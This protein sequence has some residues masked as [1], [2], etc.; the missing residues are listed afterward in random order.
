MIRTHR[1]GGHLAGFSDFIAE[2]RRRRVIR[3]LIGWGIF[4]FAVLQVVEPVLHAFHLPEW[5]LTAVVTVLGAGFP[6]TVVLA[7]VFDFTAQGITR[8]AAAGVEASPRSS[9]TGPRL[10]MLL[11]ALGL[12]A[13]APGV[14]YLFVWPGSARSAAPAPSDAQATA[15]PPSIAVLAFADLSPTKDQ[16]YFSDGIAEE[17]LNALARVKGLRVAGRTSSF[18]FK[19]RSEDLHAIGAALGV[20]NV[21][22]G[23]VRKQGN[24]VRITAQLIKARDG[25]HLWSKT[26]DGDL[27]DVFELQERIA[28]AITEELKVVLQ[29]DPQARLVPVATRN[30]EAYALYLQAT[31]IFNRRD[32]SRF[33]DAIAQLEQALALDPAYARAHSRL[34]ALHAITPSYSARNVG[35][36]MAAAEKHARRAIELDPALAEPHAVLGLLLSQQR[37]WEEER[38]AF[39]RAL[40][41]DSEDVTAN[42]WYAT[43]LVVEGYARQGAEVLD[44][45][46]V[47]DPILPNALMWRGT[48]LFNTGDLDGA[49]R[50][51][52]RASDLGLFYVGLGL[53]S[54]SDARGRREEAVE[55]LVPALRVFLGD[56]PPGS[57]DVLAR[58]I[59]GDPEARARAL[60]LVDGYLATKPAVVTGVVPYA[61]LRLGQPERAL[62]V[63]QAGPTANDA[64]VFGVLWGRYGRAAR[65][66]PSFP[67]FAR[68]VGLA[69]SWDRHGPPDGC[70]RVA[71]RDYRCE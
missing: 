5:S 70:R 18:H 31:A 25:F 3:A 7:W 6:V 29:G 37:R 26:Y 46:L 38:V 51:L 68:R 44:R 9:L 49:E 60:G 24:K 48:Q 59:F 1:A 43:T 40:A 54:V 53:S 30:P 67:E 66:L 62:E 19:G 12:L 47:L 52:R 57:A 71:P 28:R 58:G 65:A 34:A 20:D 8:T 64:L 10:A 11:L 61:L 21:L 63:L 32:G 42:F 23:S 2:L 35:A 4:S 13:A 17:I 22:E 56:F 33:A 27:T 15:G 50:L 39:Q 45:V 41:L 16:E 55:Q 36:E 14:V 69:D